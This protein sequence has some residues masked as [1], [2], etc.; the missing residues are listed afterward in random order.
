MTENIKDDAAEYWEEFF[1]KVD[2]NKDGLVSR[3]ELTNYYTKDEVVEMY[4]QI[5]QEP[6]DS[7]DID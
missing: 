2:I 1:N 5:N 6:P 7:Q 4:E 3:K